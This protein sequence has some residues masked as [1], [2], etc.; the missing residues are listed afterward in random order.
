MILAWLIIVPFVAGVLAWMSGRWSHTGP[1]WIALVGSRRDL[2]IATA[3]W[4]RAPRAVPPGAGPAV[5][6]V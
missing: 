5:P 6:A 3:L 1:R 2:L 4:I